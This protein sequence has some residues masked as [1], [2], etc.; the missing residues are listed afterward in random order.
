MV[1]NQ[2]TKV[3]SAVL[4]E[5]WISREFEG[6]LRI[7]KPNLKPGDNKR[8]RTAF[9]IAKEAHKDMRRRSGE[10][11]ILHPIA[12]ARIAVEE[13]GLGATSIIAALLHDVV[14]DTPITLEDIAK[15]TDQ[16]TAKIIDGLTKIGTFTEHVSILSAQ[17]ENLKKVLL[18]LSEDIRVILI[19]IADRLH[20]LRTMK[21]MPEAKQFKISSETLYI[22]APL[23]HRLGLY[24]IKSELEDLC[25]KYTA[26][27]SYG[28]IASKLSETKKQR[29]KYIS[30]F[31]RPLRAKLEERGLTNFEIFGRPKTIYS[32]WNKIHN[33][34]VA[35]DEIYDLF[36]IRIVIDTN[37]EEEKAEC[38]K[39][40]SIITDYYKPNPER[41]R[42]W[43]STPKSNGYESL[44][45][46]VM[47]PKGKW[48]EVQIRTKR[49]DEIAEKGYAAHWKYKN[50]G[51]AQNA[52]DEWI[53]KVRD[54]LSSPS[55]NAIDF[56]TDFKHNLYET[57]L[58]CFTPKGDLR[59]LPAGATVLDFA[60]DIHTG[61]GCSCIGAKINGKLYPI[62][63]K[64]HNGDQIEVLTSKK[65]KPN[66]DWLNFAITSKA[67]TKIK[68]M[69]KEEKRIIA[70][71]GKEILTRKLRALKQDYSKSLIE[72]LASHYRVQD[73]MTFLYNVAT[74]QF[75]LNE[76][77]NL[78]I[79]GGHLILPLPST[80]K[81]LLGKTEESNRA[82]LDT[83]ESKANDLF[84]FNGVADKVD[85]S[86]ATCCQP[87]AGDNVFG[88]LTINQG[89]KIHRM[90]C[91]NA[92]DLFKK[93]SYR[94]VNIKWGTKNAVSFLTRLKITGID[95][96]GLIQRLT[97]VISEKLKINMR[98]IAFDTTDGV[99]EGDITIYVKDV[100]Q[101]D[102]LI[103]HV[104]Q[105]E[106]VY[107]VKRSEL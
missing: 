44:H 72:E 59:T 19:K 39:A 45:L 90:N 88:F 40:Y 46:T 80:E 37:L 107:D 54:F 12:V 20:N 35:F 21:S 62:S 71:E 100:E 58:Y 53:A 73:S 36:A 105:I 70:E 30:E 102:D 98:S 6:L 29:N 60:F 74:K 13:I 16:E 86:I 94:I 96:V 10:P 8:I 47:G 38:W 28:E 77:K 69:L 34:Q 14:E 81:K 2:L 76:L 32:I 61:L 33:K 89:I 50:G 57:E 75:D 5:K 24:A 27:E 65:Q 43:I 79:Q 23:A 55:T 93:Y 99:F 78:N 82:P 106:G 9:E 42:D 25:L 3:D 104:K 4:E 48:V 51:D 67:R 85:Y 87:V 66:E 83:Q 103:Q 84:I 15:Q 41:L 91:P 7:A 56:M 18:T 22:Y 49:M 1:E 92:P 17:A 101:L 11:Y 95:D 64:L 68:S 26:R 31:I 52:L 63:H 97:A